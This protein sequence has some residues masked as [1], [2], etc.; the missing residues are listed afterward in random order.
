MI[1]QPMYSPISLTNEITRQGI[2][3]LRESILQS[4]YSIPVDDIPNILKKLPL[5]M[6]PEAVLDHF[7]SPYDYHAYSFAISESDAIITESSISN[8]TTGITKGLALSMGKPCLILVHRNNSN[9]DEKNSSIFLKN[10]NHPLLTYKE[11]SSPEEVRTIVLAFLEGVNHR[12]RVRFNLV[13]DQNHDNYLTWAA[14]QYDTTKTELITSS[15]MEK[16]ERDEL[17]Q[18][19]RRKYLETLKAKKCE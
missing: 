1:V 11:Y 3:T 5:N 13:M 18:E 17:Y 19:Q 12:V 10:F 6:T 7:T 4:G 8:S 9:P 16:A 15:I 2:I 14:T